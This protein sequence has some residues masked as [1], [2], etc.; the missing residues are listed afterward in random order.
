MDPVEIGDIELIPQADG[1]IM[2]CLAEQQDYSF[3]TVDGARHAVAYL[4]TWIMEQ[5]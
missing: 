1:R 3:W 5:E 2:I 4:Q